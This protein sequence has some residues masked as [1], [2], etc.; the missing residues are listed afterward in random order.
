MQF[1]IIVILV[2]SFTFAFIGIT[3]DYW[4]Q[5]L[6]NE[7]N[8]GL[9]IICRAQSS[10]SYSSSTSETCQKQPFFKSQALAISGL[11]LLSVTLVI[12]I[13]HRY[14]QI[15]RLSVYMT[16]AILTTSTLLLMLS[17]FLYPREFDFKE[18]GYSIYFMIS[19]TFFNLITIGLIVFNARKIQAM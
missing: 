13:I 4:Y 1:L 15:D 3:T 14:R 7:F 10:N 6:L 18:L 12:S 17:Y 16:I 19:S 8:E 11:L 5:S 9:W 2:V